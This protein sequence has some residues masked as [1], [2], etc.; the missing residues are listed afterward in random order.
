VPRLL[1][2]RL[3]KKKKRISIDVYFSTL[4]KL[5]MSLRELYERDT[6]K[7]IDLTQQQGAK[8]CGGCEVASPYPA[9]E[10]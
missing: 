1:T 10:Q 2:A 8:D 6:L 5:P 9:E 7:R 3:E 4:C